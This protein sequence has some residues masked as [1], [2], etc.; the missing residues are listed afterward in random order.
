MRE[1][2]LE[3]QWKSHS[4]RSMP[5]VCSRLQR[6][7]AASRERGWSCGSPKRPS[8]KALEEVLGVTLFKRLPRGLAPTDEGHALL[9]VLTDAF[10]RFSATLSQFEE[11]NFRHSVASA[12]TLR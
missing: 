11:G 3:R 12:P 4:Y 8:V 9:P 7:T 6:D 2:G 5:C 1:I 10:H